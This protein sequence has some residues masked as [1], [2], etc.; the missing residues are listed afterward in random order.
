[1]LEI[2]I[3]SYENEILSLKKQIDTFRPLQKSQLAN[4][5][6]WFKIGFTAESNA[7]EGNTFTPSEVKVLIEDGITVW[8]KTI[9]ELKETQN[10]AELTDEIWN[11][12]EKDFLLT[13]DFLFQLHKKLLFGIEKENVW[14]YRDFQVYI[15]WSD[16]KLPSSKEVIWLM[17]T[18]VNFCNTDEENILQKISNIHFEFVKIHPFVDGNWR[19]ARLLM[20]MYLV[21]YWFFPIIFPVVT[22]FEYISSLWKNKTQKDFY[23]Y[24]LWQTKENMNDY[25]R[26]F[27]D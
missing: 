6:S 3:P 12:F 4:L 7:L 2:D 14:K 1:M 10:L 26:F 22:R 16:E 8:G 11:F 9:K 25:V 18:F 21:K 23:K 13:H 27:N 20:N 5:Q 17:D 15:S 24:F 19:I